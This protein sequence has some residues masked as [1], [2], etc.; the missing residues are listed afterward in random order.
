MLLCKKDT[1][2]AGNLLMNDWMPC[3]MQKTSAERWHQALST[4][5]DA[6]VTASPSEYAILSKTKPEKMQLYALEEIVL[7]AL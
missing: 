5:V 4:G 6:L 7:K 1:V 3:V 2:W